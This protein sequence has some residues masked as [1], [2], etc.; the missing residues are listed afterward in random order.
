[1]AFRGWVPTV[2][3]RL[4][5][6]LI[7]QTR[8]P[9]EAEYANASTVSHSYILAIQTR[10]LSDVLFERVLG[11]L[12]GISGRFDFVFAA[13]S[14]HGTPDSRLIGRVYVTRADGKK[15]I[16]ESAG[17]ADHL[18]LLRDLH[19]RDPDG[20]ARAD[21]LASH[22]HLRDNCDVFADVVLQRN[23]FFMVSRVCWQDGE[24]QR[25]SAS[26]ASHE[27]DDIDRAIGDQIYFFVRDLAHQHQHHG[28]DAD[29]IITTVPQAGDSLKWC[30]HIVYGLYHHVIVAK[31]KADPVEHVRVLGVLAYLRSF[32]RIVED[33][34]QER[35]QQSALPKF[36]D[37]ATKESITATKNYIEL[38]AVRRKQGS[39]EFRTVL[40]TVTAT[41]LTLV[42]F[43][44][45]FA[46]EKAKPIPPMQELANFLKENAYVCFAPLAIVVVWWLSSWVIR[47]RYDFKRDVLRL[48]I[49]NRNVAGL[50]LIVASVLVAVFGLANLWPA[51]TAMSK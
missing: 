15:R 48:S 16:E 41:A 32:K 37:D 4:S 50:I 12:F 7:G 10:N 26:F 20:P 25:R 17:L 21:Y 9:Q 1:M 42:S 51:L 35:S 40:F 49:V 24:F 28:P 23:G 33:A 45:G 44:S 34:A 36:D 11:R 38:L 18:K 47:P 19:Y 27:G 3:G 5:F 39:D 30:G 46:E 8:Y 13:R 29:T 14:R 22:E 2:N 31:R 6:K 43:I